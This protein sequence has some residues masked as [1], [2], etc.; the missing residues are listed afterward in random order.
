M[1]SVKNGEARRVKLLNM[2]CL[3]A[4]STQAVIHN[5]FRFESVTIHF[6]TELDE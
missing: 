5:T 1:P 4:V 3:Q 2:T 6:K